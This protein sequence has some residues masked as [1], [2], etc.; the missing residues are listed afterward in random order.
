MRYGIGWVLVIGFAA[1]CSSRGP[2]ESRTISLPSPAAGRAELLHGAQY[3][4]PELVKSVRPD[5]PTDRRQVFTELFLMEGPSTTVSAA[6]LSDLSQLARDPRLQLLAAPHL[7]TDVGQRTEETLVEHIGVSQQ[8][9]LYQVSVLPRESS[10]GWVV[11]ELGMTLQLPNANAAAPAPTASTTLTMT[12]PEQQ[13]LLSSAALPHG[14]DRALLVLAKYWRIH[15]TL[16]L[17]DIFECKMRQR[18]HALSKQ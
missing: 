15:D 7:I 9:S 14:R 5:T 18:Q 2:A 4:C 13:L 8:A 16:D 17:R 3:G 6:R 11:L 1:G 12:G 10:E